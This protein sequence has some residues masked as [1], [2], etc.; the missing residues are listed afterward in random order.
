LFGAEF[1]G[2]GR[3]RELTAQIAATR[4]AHSGGTLTAASDG[5]EPDHQRTMKAPTDT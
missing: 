4:Q 3:A 5:D 1:P 2:E